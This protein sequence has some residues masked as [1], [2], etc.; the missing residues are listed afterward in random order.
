MSTDPGE[1]RFPFDTTVAHPARVY[2]YWLGGK[3]NFAAAYYTGLEM[4]EPGL[5]QLPR[6]RP[7]A[8]DPDPGPVL[9]AY[10]AVARKP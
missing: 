2:N 6:W 8:D 3:D 5:V 9:S 7:D 10:C 4:V 1:P